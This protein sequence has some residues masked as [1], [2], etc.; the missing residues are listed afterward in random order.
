MLQLQW[1]RPS[2]SQKCDEWIK[3]LNQSENASLV[4]LVMVE[5]L[6]SNYTDLKTCHKVR[7][8]SVLFTFKMDG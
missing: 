4:V 8:K 2:S 7:K 3:K 5:R 6:T 1:V